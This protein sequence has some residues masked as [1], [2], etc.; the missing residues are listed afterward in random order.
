MNSQQGWNF[1]ILRVLA[2]TPGDLEMKVELTEFR[3]TCVNMV[4]V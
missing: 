2:K 3:K 4:K 1:E